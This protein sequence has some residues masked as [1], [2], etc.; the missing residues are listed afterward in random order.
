MEVLAHGEDHKTSK[1]W[2]HFPL[3]NISPTLKSVELGSV[4][5][6]QSHQQSSHLQNGPMPWNLKGSFEG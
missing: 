1:Y 2:I 3:L 6:I 5:L 4:S